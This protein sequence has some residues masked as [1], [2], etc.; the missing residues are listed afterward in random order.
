MWG[1]LWL[2]LRYVEDM[3][4]VGIWPVVAINSW[5]LLIL[6]P[7][8][9]WRWRSL[10]P[11]LKLC[12]LFGFWSGAGLGLYATG[13]LYSSVVRATMLFYLTPV[14]SMLAA[15]FLLKERTPWQSWIAILCGLAGLAMMLG[16]GDEQSMPFNI[17]D[18]FG[19]LSGFGWAFA[20]IVLRRH[21]DL[22]PI[23]TTAWQFFFASLIP[24]LVG[25]V[26]LTDVPTPTPAQWLDAGVVLGL[27]SVCILL[28]SL[29]LIFKLGG[30]LPPVRV[31]ILM[32]SEVVVAIITASLFANEYMGLIEWLGAALILTAVVA[33]VLLTNADPKPS[34][35][36]S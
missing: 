22:P 31:G 20:I 29:L 6:I 3:G 14:W 19:L 17:G 25:Y 16:G 12:I 9:I 30:T 26:L 24:I 15:Y 2:P 21:P 33:E 23:A 7:I 8:M 36:G 18:V 13:L 35:P 1:L 11:T 27:F 32:M 28:P 34:A 4:V 10:Q 5:P